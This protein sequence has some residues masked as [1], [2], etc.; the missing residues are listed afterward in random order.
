MEKNLSSENL[1]LHQN[2]FVINVVLTLTADIVFNV[3]H[4]LQPDANTDTVFIKGVGTGRVGV[5]AF[6]THGR[7]R[8]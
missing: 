8:R 4:L 2:F 3:R 7:P 1:Y 5:F 6:T